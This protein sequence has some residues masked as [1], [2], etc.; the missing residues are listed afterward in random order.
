MKSE[1]EKYCLHVYKK[2]REQK[3]NTTLYRKFSFASYIV[4]IEQEKDRIVH[5][6]IDTS[7]TFYSYQITQCRHMAA[8]RAS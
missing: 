3:I 6:Y 1:N 5:I 7:V 4:L 8:S 2:E